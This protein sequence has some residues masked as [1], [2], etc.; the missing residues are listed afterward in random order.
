ME[1]AMIVYGLFA[2]LITVMLVVILIAAASTAIV[3]G[4]RRSRAHPKADSPPPGPS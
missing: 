3:R 4:V 2:G 1:A